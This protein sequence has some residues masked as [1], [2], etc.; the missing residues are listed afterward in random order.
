MSVVESSR[1][2]PSKTGAPSAWAPSISSR[3]ASL[4]K[5]RLRAAPAFTGAATSSHQAQKEHPI[6]TFVKPRPVSPGR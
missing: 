5:D 6:Q 2:A 4:S 3:G 1:F